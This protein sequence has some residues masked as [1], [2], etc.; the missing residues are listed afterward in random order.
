[1]IV[2][3]CPVS[4]LPS[5]HAAHACG[6]LARVG[7]TSGTAAAPRTRITASV[8]HPTRFGGRSAAVRRRVSR[9]DKSAR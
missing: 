4:V 3:C 1:M 5:P 2:S 9:R 7:L 6:P 8:P